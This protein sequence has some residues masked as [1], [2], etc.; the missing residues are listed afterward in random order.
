M[1]NLLLILT[2]LISSV[3]YGQP[4]STDTMF[5]ENVDTSFIEKEIFRVINEY[6]VSKGVDVLEWDTAY[7]NGARKHSEWLSETGLFVHDE[8]SLTNE[9]I[10]GTNDGN[11][12]FTYGKF[13]DIVVTR[14]KNSPGHN[15]V[16]LLPRPNY[17]GVGISFNEGVYVGNAITTFRSSEYHK[18]II[19]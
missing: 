2:I 18:K 11:N 8:K 10:V 3:V 9:C 7:S 6:R 16:M 5:V 4:K 13:A 12:L 17:G 14:W 15:Y 1:K 19:F